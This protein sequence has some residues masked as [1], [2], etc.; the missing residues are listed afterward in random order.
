MHLFDRQFIKRTNPLV[1]FYLFRIYLLFTANQFLGEH[2]FY[3]SNDYCLIDYQM[4]ISDHSFIDRT[5]LLKIL[6]LLLFYLL[7]YSSDCMSRLSFGSLFLGRFV[8]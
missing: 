6:L 2:C 3:V 5:N 4:Y 1:L 7:Q 8:S